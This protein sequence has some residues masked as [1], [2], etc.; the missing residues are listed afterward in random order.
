MTQPRNRRLGLQLMLVATFFTGFGFAL[1]PLYDVLCRLTGL[2][3]RTNAVAAAR[4]I[5]TQVVDSRWVK[6]E[7]L[8]HTMPGVGLE[9]RPE[10]F[11]MQV[12]PGAVIQTNY[13]VRNTAGQSFTGQA[14]P[15]ITPAMAAGHF[16]K[17]ECFCFSQQTLAPSEVRTMPLVF[18]V[19][20]ALDPDIRTI[21]LSYTFFEAP[22]AR[23]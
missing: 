18:V 3:G 1:V 13:V 11:S 19:D 22:K 15:S 7:F 12:H 9:L 2:N 6:V 23:T 10:Q 5:N 4:P 17:I 16:S 21:T 14:V 20:E 8:A